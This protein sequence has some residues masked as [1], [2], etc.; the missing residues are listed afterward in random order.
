MTVSFSDGGKPDVIH[1]TS[2]SETLSTGK[3]RRK[4][5]KKKMVKLNSESARQLELKI[6]AN[7]N[8]HELSCQH[9]LCRQFWCFTISQAILTMLASILAFVASSDLLTPVIKT[10]LNLLVGSLSAIVVFLQTLSGICTFGDR[11]G[12]HSNL[13]I[14]LRDLRDDIALLRLKLQK[15]EADDEKN[16][17]SVA[18]ESSYYDDYELD[19]SKN[20]SKT[21]NGDKGVEDEDVN[22]DNFESIQQRYRQSL[23]GCKSNSPMQISEAFYGLESHL[24]VSRSLDNDL[25]MSQVYGH[26]NHG[27]L[28]AWKGYDILCTQISTYYLFP[29]FLPSPRYAVDT[30]MKLLNTQLNQCHKYWEAQVKE[31]FGNNKKFMKKSFFYSYNPSSSSEEV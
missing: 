4:K 21:A 20:G 13:A 10:Y 29:M 2:L 15:V 30:T 27:N 9:F 14:D 11:A 8:R 28:V 7:M 23:A 31:N 24:L 22:R 17:G 19:G 1:T 5:K 25:Y 26:N 16:G 3:R 18:D 12:M 6:Q